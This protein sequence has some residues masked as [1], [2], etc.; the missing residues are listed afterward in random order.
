MLCIFLLMV[1]CSNALLIPIKNNKNI[2]KTSQLNCNILS[3]SGGGS[4]GAVQM[5]VLDGLLQDGIIPDTYD[6]ITGISA[7]GL[8][9][10][11]LS[12]YTHVS[13][14]LPKIYSI[15]SNLTTSDIYTNN[16]FHILSTYGI[17]STSPLQNTLSS[18]VGTQTQQSPAPITLIGST[19]VNNQ[20]LDVFQYN[21]ADNSEKVQLLM[22]ASAIPFVFPPQTMNNQL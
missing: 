15:Y 14:A 6:I 3:L 21:L 20:T 9:A 4:F 13:D 18:I 2:Q 7:G 17:Y 12:Y 19:N 22:A 10:G 8:N 11:F 1:L 5:G 16:I